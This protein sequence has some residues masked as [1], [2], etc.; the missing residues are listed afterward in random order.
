MMPDLRKTGG[1]SLRDRFK[2][3]DLDHFALVVEGQATLHAVSWSYK[4]S[5]GRTLLESFPVLLLDGMLEM[6]DQGMMDP[7]KASILNVK[8]IFKE[9][10]RLQ[11]GLDHIYKVAIP[12]SKIYYNVPLKQDEL[13]WT[14][15]SVLKKPAEPVPNE[16]D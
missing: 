3:L 12:L 5:T 1:Y 7:I 13:H 2:G 16:G 11:E 8:N 4:K 6:Y 14:K 15:D 9:Q 10:P